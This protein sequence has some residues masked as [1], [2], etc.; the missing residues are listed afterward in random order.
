MSSLQF[1][2]IR[3]FAV[4][5]LINSIRGNFLPFHS[6]VRLVKTF[7]PPAEDCYTPKWVPGY[8]TNLRRCDSMLQMIQQY[9]Q[10]GDAD[11]VT[12]LQNSICGYD[13]FDMMV[14]CPSPRFQTTTVAPL[15]FFTFGPSALPGSTFAPIINAPSQTTPSSNPWNNPQTFAPINFTPGPPSPINPAPPPPP[16]SN[17]NPQTPLPAAVF[18]TSAPATT[19]PSILPTFERDRCG[20]SNAT[21]SRVVGGLPAQVNAWPWIALIGYR[22]PLDSNPRF[23][24]GGTLISQKH[25][26][27]AAHCVKESL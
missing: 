14:C 1:C 2:V 9:N 19:I 26:L 25:V 3:I 17:A 24:C 6:L 10:N 11:I 20:M 5:V 7:L 22:N 4:V 23:L 13:G 16:P 8:C 12:Y 15:Y 21:H 18:P 27:T